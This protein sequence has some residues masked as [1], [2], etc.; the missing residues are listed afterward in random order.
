MIAQIKKAPLSYRI[1]EFFYL[2]GG[3]ARPRAKGARRSAA[4]PPSES[5]A[6]KGHGTGFAVRCGNRKKAPL[7][8][9][10]APEGS[11]A[12]AV[13]GGGAIGALPN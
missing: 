4:K 13:R 6:P 1:G 12:P 10:V 3:E 2:C 11:E 9:A 7:S 5:H 8:A